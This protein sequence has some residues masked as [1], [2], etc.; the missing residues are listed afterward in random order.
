M[1]KIEHTDQE[2]F[3]KNGY[4]CPPEGFAEITEKEFVQHSGFFDYIP[5]LIE[6]RQIYVD[7]DLK[8]N[9]SG[10]MLD[11][12]MYWMDKYGGYALKRE[13][14]EGTIRYFKFGCTHENRREL[15]QKECNERGIA[16]F[17]MCWHVEECK[18]GKI[19]SYD[20]S[21]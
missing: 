1:Y 6:H 11:I 12:V 2:S 7:K 21:D 13:Y 19:S 9:R 18:C 15:S 20:S 3:D 8:S 4:N 5:M 14:W 10:T 16:H 17:G